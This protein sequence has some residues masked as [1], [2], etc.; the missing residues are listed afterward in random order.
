M[1]LCLGK[2]GMAPGAFWALSW[3]EFTAAAEGFAEFHGGGSGVK[4]PTKEEAAELIERADAMLRKQ[5]KL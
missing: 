5:G 2:M 1:A 4:P 3:V